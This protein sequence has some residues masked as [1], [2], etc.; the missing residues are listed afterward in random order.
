MRKTIYVAIGAGL[1]LAVVWLAMR[2]DELVPAA[3]ALDASL[4]AHWDV[5]APDANNPEMHETLTA[6]REVASSAKASSPTPTTDR[7]L[8]IDVT[9]GF[10]VL[11]KKSD[12]LKPTD[13]TRALVLRH[14]ELQEQPRDPGWS[15]RIEAALRKGIQDSLTSRGLDTQRIELTF[16][17]G[18]DALIAQGLSFGDAQAVWPGRAGQCR[19]SSSSR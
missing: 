3:P 19:C 6:T 8:P 11:H 14:E 5:A 2:K 10:D 13:P 18:V 7:A 16:R 17:I 1:V 9:P 4:A 12:S 15:D